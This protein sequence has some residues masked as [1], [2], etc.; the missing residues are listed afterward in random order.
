MIRRF[1]AAL[2]MLVICGAVLIAAEIRGQVVS[3]KDN[4][5]T[6]N[7]FKKK[8]EEPEKKTYKIAKDAKFF[9]GKFDRDAKKVVEGDKID[10]SDIKEKARVTLTVEDDKVT[11]ILVFQGKGGKKKG[12]DQ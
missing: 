5:I 11:K 12:K 7:V 10:L 3:I 9:K 6:V 1:A 2:V 4:E 8:G